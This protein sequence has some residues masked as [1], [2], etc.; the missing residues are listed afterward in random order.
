MSFALIGSVEVAEEVKIVQQEKRVGPQG[1]E[2][3]GEL[4]DEPV[5]ENASSWGLV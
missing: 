3:W 4:V 2:G 1:G 5:L